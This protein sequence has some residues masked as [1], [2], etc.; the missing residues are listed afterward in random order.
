[1]ASENDPTTPDT[2]T[3]EGV[4]EA[5]AEQAPAEKPKSRWPGIG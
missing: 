5:P 1:M 3:L 4:F 2:T